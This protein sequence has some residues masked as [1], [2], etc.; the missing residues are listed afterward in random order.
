MKIRKLNDILVRW[1]I[2]ETFTSLDRQE[3]LDLKLGKTLDVDN[4]SALW[5]IAQG[6]CEHI[7]TG[8]EDHGLRDS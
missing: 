1:S 8:V 6:Y 4:E 7:K 2:V 5:L 3:F